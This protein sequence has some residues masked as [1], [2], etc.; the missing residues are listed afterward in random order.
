MCLQGNYSDD[1]HFFAAQIMKTKIQSAFTEVPEDAHESLRDALCASIGTLAGTGTCTPP[2]HIAA[3]CP[4]HLAILYAKR[5]PPVTCSPVC[6]EGLSAL[7]SLL[8]RAG[9]L[10][11]CS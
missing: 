8:T 5:V 7:F 10:R 3:P 1:V 6:L 9:Y 11:C 2:H 4:S